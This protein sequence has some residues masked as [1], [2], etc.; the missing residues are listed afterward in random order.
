MRSGPYVNPTFGDLRL[1]CSLLCVLVSILRGVANGFKKIIQHQFLRNND[2][3]LLELD[4][5]FI[6]KGHVDFAD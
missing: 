1:R 6:K 3:S 4:E 2:E 5:Q